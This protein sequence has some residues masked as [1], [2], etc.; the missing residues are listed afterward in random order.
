MLTNNTPLAT[1][2]LPVV[3]TVVK[4]PVFG[5]ALPIVV[6]SMAPPFTSIPANVLVPALVISPVT[7]PVKLPEKPVL[8][9]IVVPVTAAGTAP[10]IIALSMAPPLTS[11]LAKELVPALVMLPVTLP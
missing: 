1:S 10:P 4:A 11:M 5:V 8:A 2:R 9:V 3:V 7:L 6:L